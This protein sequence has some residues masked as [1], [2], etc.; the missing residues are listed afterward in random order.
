MW[1]NDFEFT[2]QS[3]DK[4]F[5]YFGTIENKLNNAYYFDRSII[6][7][8]SF[9]EANNILIFGR[10]SAF[11]VLAK[12]FLKIPLE[13]TELRFKDLD[14]MID[15]SCKIKM[16]IIDKLKIFIKKLKN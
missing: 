13:E 8:F 3:F 11:N 12:Y 1:N 9:F 5:Y 15:P 4:K 7:L 14:L 10:G 6:Y 2:K 16:D